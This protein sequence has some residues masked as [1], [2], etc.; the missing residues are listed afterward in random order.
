MQEP[1][2]EICANMLDALNECLQVRHTLI[3]LELLF[4]L[5]YCLSFACCG[6]GRKKRKRGSV[7]GGGGMFGFGEIFCCFLDFEF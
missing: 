5:E 2:T 4:L 7:L 3:E 1:D 6:K